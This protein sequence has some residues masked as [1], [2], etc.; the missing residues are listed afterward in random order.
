MVQFICSLASPL[1][2]PGPG[3]II[4]WLQSVY[5]GMPLHPC[6]QALGSPLIPLGSTH[7]LNH[8]N[9]EQGLNQFESSL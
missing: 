6:H 8:D 1:H 9:Q 2:W 5:E 3:I 4:N 7:T